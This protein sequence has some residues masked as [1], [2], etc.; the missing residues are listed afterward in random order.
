MKMVIA[1]SNTVH[2]RIES[3]CEA[4]YGAVVIHSKDQLTYDYLKELKPDYIFF[5]HWSFIIPAEIYDNFNC[6]VFH[7]TDLPFG[8]GGSP[9]QNLIVRGYRD[10]VISALRVTKGI[11]TGPVYLKRPLSLSGSAE[12]IFKRAGEEMLIMIDEIVTTDP[13]PVEQKGEIIHFARRTPKESNLDP[14]SDIRSLYDHIRMLDAP[15]YPKAF[16]ETAH[17]R[18]EF[19][20]AEIKDEEVTANVKITKK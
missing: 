3:L 4:K 18:F 6:V 7:M 12:Q 13:K 19:S 14:V 15:G 5:L 1:N 9:L 10:T 11:D 8:R 16:I 20:G 17:L 2:S